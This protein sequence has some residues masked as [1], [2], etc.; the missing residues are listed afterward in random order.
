MSPIRAADPLY[1]EARRTDASEAAIRRN[2]EIGRSLSRRIEIPEGVQD[3]V[4][5]G[6]RP[7]A[8]RKGQ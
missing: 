4:I 8:T 6:V 7:I 1:R 5:D 3:I 2:V